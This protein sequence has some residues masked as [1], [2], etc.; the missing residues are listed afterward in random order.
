MKLSAVVHTLNEEHNIEACLKTLS[1]ADEIVVVDNE[2]TDNTVSIAKAC[3]ARIEVFTEHYGY[4]EPARVFGLSKLKGD[5]VFILDADERVT[6]ELADEIINVINDPA[7]VDGYWV[8]IRNYHFG[9]W[10]KHGKLY[11]DLHMRFFKREKGGYP[12][13]GLHRGIVVDGTVEQVKHDILHYS[14][15]N[16]E[17]YFQKLNIYT[18]AEGKRIVEQKRL[19]TGYDVFIKPL[20]RFLKSYIVQG[21]MRDGLEG[22]MFHL[23]SALYVFISELKAWELYRQQGKTLPMLKT[24]FSRKRKAKK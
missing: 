9:R 3:G 12:E 5:W 13:V 17:H 1:F 10:L 15:K 21:G 14:Y 8:P 11:P 7:S 20:H 16:I 24:L 22:Y 23:F 6:T 2:S 19:P 18:T 4:P